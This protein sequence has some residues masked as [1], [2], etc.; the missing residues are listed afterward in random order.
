VIRLRWTTLSV[1]GYALAATI[2]V[3][4][5]GVIAR[6]LGPI[7]GGMVFILA[8]GCVFGVTI[9]IPAILGAPPGVVRRREWILLSAIGASIGF[10]LAAF[11]G[12]RLGDVVSPTGNII[13]GGATIQILSGATLGLTIGVA[14][15]RALDR[16][17]GIGRRWILATIVGTGLGYGA[18]TGVLELLDV[19]ILRA[20]LIPSFGAIVGLSVGVAQGF[21]LR[22]R[23]GD[24]S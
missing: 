17:L 22:S 19:E 9:A 21:V 6:P 20:N 18:A 14:Q 15:S 10:A 8:F 13:I 11:A 5:L 24:R 3:A 1:V 2:S 4:L 23:P 12:E 7:A 16:S